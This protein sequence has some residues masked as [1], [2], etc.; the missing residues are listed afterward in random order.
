MICKIDCSIRVSRSFAKFSCKKFCMILAYKIYFA[1]NYSMS[2][3]VVLCTL[4]HHIY[5]QHTQIHT[6]THMCTHTHTPYANANA[7]TILLALKRHV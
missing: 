7:H 3:H 5:Y 2:I 4:M 6:H 1:Q